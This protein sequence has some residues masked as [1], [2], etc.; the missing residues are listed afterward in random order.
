V[1]IEPPTWAEVEAW[2]RAVLSETVT[3]EEGHDWAEP[4]MLATYDGNTEPDVLALS[5]LQY[6]HGFDMTSEDAVQRFV[7]HG[8]PGDHIKPM[9]EVGTGL[10]RWLSN[11]REYDDDP[12]AWLARV[13]AQ[14]R[15]A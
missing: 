2:W 12:V 8:P 11:C 14:A 6:L 13:R 3:R 7:A 9:S 4:L 10:D 5:G 15:N 1:G